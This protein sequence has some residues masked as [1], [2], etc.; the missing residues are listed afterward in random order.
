MRDGPTCAAPT[1]PYHHRCDRSATTM[2]N[3]RLPPEIPTY[4]PDA[5]IRGRMRQFKADLY[6]RYDRTLD[7]KA[8]FKAAATDFCLRGSDV[9]RRRALAKMNRVLAP[10][11]PTL[12]GVWLKGREPIAIWSALKARNAIFL[13]E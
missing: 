6:G 4:Y 12:E 2:G 7:N 13:H 9:G 3:I 8:A 10:A 1:R 5:G 11:R